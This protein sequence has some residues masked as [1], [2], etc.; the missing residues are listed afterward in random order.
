M[1]NDNYVD[2]ILVESDRNVL[3]DTKMMKIVFNEINNGSFTKF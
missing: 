3:T 2:G 1:Y